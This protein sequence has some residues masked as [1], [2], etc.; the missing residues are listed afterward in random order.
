MYN[1]HD[2]MQK[3]NHT[4]NSS[5]PRFTNVYDDQSTCRFKPVYIA[6]EPLVY[7]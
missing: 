5:Q 3:P 1:V 6:I 2:I 7:V 4:H